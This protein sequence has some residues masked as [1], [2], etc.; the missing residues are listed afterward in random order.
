MPATGRVARTGSLGLVSR[1][2][3]R[4]VSSPRVVL[5]VGAV[6]GALAL[7]GCGAGQITQTS[8][9]VSGVG[10]ASAN[11]G[12][13]AIREAAFAFTG[14]GKTAVIYPPG[15]TAPL[16]MT[17]VNFGAQDDKLDGRVEPGRGVGDDQR[18]RHDRQRAA[19][20]GRRRARRPRRRPA[21]APASARATPA[22]G[23]ARAIPA[24][25]ATP[26][27]GG[28]T[29]T[30]APGATAAAA[31]PTSGVGAAAHHRPARCGHHHRSGRPHR[32]EAEPGGGP[33]L[34][35]RAD[36]PACR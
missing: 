28:A 10:G 8:S 27:P 23:T 24:P 5:A 22:P 17:V 21:A 2:V 32:F 15:G 9:Q 7:A 34:P 33:D 6:V 13:I 18:G 12:Q 11:V 36:L 30:P 29:A 25:S 26:A 20:A 16:T 14:N 19:A 3:S 31:P 35:R 4:S 1:T